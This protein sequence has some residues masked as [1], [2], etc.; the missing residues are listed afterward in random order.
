MII[1]HIFSLIAS[2]LVGVFVFSQ[3]SKTK[4]IFVIVD[5][6]SSDAIEKVETPNLDAVAKEGGYTHAYVGGEKGG[7]SETPTISAVGYNSL[8]TGTWA[9][10]HNVW[11]NSI[12]SPN[13]SS[14]HTLFEVLFT[15][16][17]FFF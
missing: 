6:I 5:G 9:N 13:Y 10:K 3:E 2:F 12:K 15:I 14:T 7:Y 4:V 1:K 16:V 8:L 17:L 11:G